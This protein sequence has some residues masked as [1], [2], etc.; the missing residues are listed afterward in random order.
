MYS[1]VLTVTINLD[2]LQQRAQYRT[3]CSC[4]LARERGPS[5]PELLI[6]DCIHPL[7]KENPH[8]DISVK[9]YKQEKKKQHLPESPILWR[10]EVSW[11]FFWIRNFGERLHALWALRPKYMLFVLQ[12][13]GISFDH[14][15]SIFN[16]LT[17]KPIRT[18]GI[19]RRMKK[20][21]Q[22]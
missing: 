15:L 12:G 13:K 7:Q 1:L 8:W 5:T 9:V 3:P 6:T 16:I 17:N 19:V 4:G 18:Q 22:L 2:P 10:Q 20:S 14:F 11:Q 21:K